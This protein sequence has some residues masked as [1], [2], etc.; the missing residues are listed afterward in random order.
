[1]PVVVL[2]VCIVAALS[3]QGS[4]M[5]GPATSIKKQVASESGASGAPAADAA[6][7]AA[8]GDAA[9]MD[10]DAPAAVPAPAAGAAASG[11]QAA[12]AEGAAAAG[13]AAA[14]ATPAEG[15]PAASAATLTAHVPG[16]EKSFGD[17]A[18]DMAMALMAILL[19]PVTSSRVR[20]ST[21]GCLEIV[22]TAV[23]R[24]ISAWLAKILKNLN[25]QSTITRRMLPLKGVELA[26]GQAEAFTFCLAQQ[27]AVIEMG[28]DAKAFLSD[29]L[30]LAES[31][32]PAL[33]GRPSR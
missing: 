21:R 6:A 3:L 24:P 23:G 8:A 2:I 29:A 9:P 19:N 10:T 14:G 16:L 25:G 13:G 32:D 20:A 15:A 26:T 33:L 18:E 1:M 4:S 30:T 28:D 5:S 27:P 17:V 7:A 31:D 12:T 11:E 22:S